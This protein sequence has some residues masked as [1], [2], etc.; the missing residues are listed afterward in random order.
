VA[1]VSLVLSSL[2]CAPAIL[3]VNHKLQVSA[4]PG[5]T[6]G[7]AQLKSIRATLAAAGRILQIKDDDEDIEC[8]VVFE[9]AEP[10]LRYNHSGV[11]E[12]KAS[13]TALAAEP[14]YVKI[15]NEFLV[16]GDKIVDPFVSGCGTSGPKP[17]FAVKADAL[18]HAVLWVHEFGH[19]KRLRHREETRAQAPG[20]DLPNPNAVMVGLI[21]TDANRIV[22][23]VEC[24]AFS[25]PIPV[26][27]VMPTTKKK[28]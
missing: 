14:G 23:D 13:W 12:D 28:N 19:T 3:A 9:M 26:Y 7:E 6:I 16:C 5:M 21:L 25:D 17:T 24:K 2:L 10:V 8:N 20:D 22:S 11:V 15:V 18:N 27:R 1:L 4:H